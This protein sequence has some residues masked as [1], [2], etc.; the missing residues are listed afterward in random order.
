VG[1]IVETE[2]YCGDCYTAGGKAIHSS[3]YYGYKGVSYYEQCFSAALQ[4]YKPS[5]ELMLLAGASIA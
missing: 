5:L 2:F 1:V 3:W 4:S